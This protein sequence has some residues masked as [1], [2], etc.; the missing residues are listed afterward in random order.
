MAD[1]E[2]F[3]FN[4][5]PIFAHEYIEN[6]EFRFKGTIVSKFPLDQY[7]INIRNKGGGVKSSGTF[8]VDT[9]ATHPGQYCYEF[10]KT[11]D[12]DAGNNIVRLMV[13]KEGQLLKDSVSVFHFP[14]RPNLHLLS[15][16]INN[17][18]EYADED[19][20][21]FAKLFVEQE[22][23][24]FKNVY[25]TVLSTPNQTTAQNVINEVLYLKDRYELL[26]NPFITS[27]DVLIVFISSHGTMIDGSFTLLANGFREDNES[28]HL[29]FQ[30]HIMDKLES[31]DCRKLVF[32]D[33]CKSGGAQ[34]SLD[35]PAKDELIDNILRIANT[36]PGISILSSCGEKQ[37]SFEDD[38]FKNGLFTEAIIQGL[39]A[40]SSLVNPNEDKVITLDE[41]YRYLKV[42]VPQLAAQTYNNNPDK[43]QTPTMPTNELDELFP[44]FYLGKAFY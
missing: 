37:A 31:I 25:Q 39:S 19:A 44:L 10:E 1:G 43:K 41:L 14:Q 15:I 42:R 34:K 38:S 12:L 13:E 30:K 29:H 4:H 18:L 21:D 28:T 26:R 22:N 36:A 7:E 35:D 40:P 16:G 2:Y 20:R 23:K 8:F 11:I 24:L 9:V 32:L 33:A 5:G 27:D 17:D 6:S 3:Y